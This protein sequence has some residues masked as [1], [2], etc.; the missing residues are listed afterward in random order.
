MSKMPAIS[1]A[2]VPGRRKQTLDMAKQLEK[3]GFSGIYCPSFGDNL[4]LCEA[5]ALTTE[6]ITFGTSIIPIYTRHVR[7]FAQHV[8]FIHEISNGRFR[9]GV[10]VSH[11][12]MMTRMGL[13]QGKPLSDMRQ[14]VE[15]IQAV[16]RV[17]DLPP[18]VLAALRD[19]MIKLAAEI[20]DG[21]VF[22]N[23]ARSYMQHSLAVLPEAA[24]SNK[25]FFI[26]NMIPTVIS[27]DRK[28]A[29]AVNKKTMSSYLRLPNYRNY[30]KAAGYEEEMLAVEKAI[31]KGNK[32]QLTDC[33]SEKW[34]ADVTLF[35]TASE[36]REGVE[37]WFDAGIR[38]PILV[39]SSAS[40]GQM[41]AID[42]LMACFR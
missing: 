7:D 40:G 9:F 41:Q 28:A 39:P 17:G 10:G 12:P 31:A 2:A 6:S 36:V 5:L 13:Q 22:A 29:M 4:A 11:T 42:E 32:D 18:L 14:F 35:G 38:T 30:W 1:L 3:A 34:L 37:R 33:I 8:A 15:D 23:G 19:K 25:D 26:G 16:G 27:D 20:A 24:R 21:L